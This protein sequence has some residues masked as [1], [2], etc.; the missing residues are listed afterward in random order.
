MI[1]RCLLLLA[2]LAG[3]SAVWSQDDDEGRLNSATFSGLKMRTTGPA[4]MS[5]RVADIA[6]HPHDDNVWY[7]AVGS[8]GVWK[9]ANAGITWSSIFD[10]QESYSIGALSIDQS[11]PSI[12]WVG[13]GE[14]VGGRHVGFGDG[15]YRSAD[16]GS[17]WK[18][19]GLKES[20]HISKIIV[21]P[22]NSDVVWV[23][24]QGPLWSKGGERGLYKTSDAGNTWTR[25]L[26]GDE[27]D[28]LWTGV[29]DLV[30]D[31]RNPDVL[32]AAT[33]QRHRT[34]AAYVGGG[35]NSG[36]HRSYDGGETWEKLSTGL[37]QGNL[38]KIGLA[39][40][41]Q[42]PDVLYAAIE[43]NQRTGGVYRSADRGSSWQKRSDT[44]SGGT[45]PHYYQEL[46]ASPHAFDRLYLM[47]V[48]IQISD[49]G[50][51]TFRIMD[52][53]HKH[54]DNHA[55]VFRADDPD[56]LLAGTDGG[57]YESF[58]LAQNWR[59]IANLPVTQFYKIAVDDKEPFYTI[60]GGTQDNSTQ[61]GPSRTD[62]MHGARNSDWEIVLFADGHQPATE[63][64]NPDIMYAEWQQG[65]LVRVDRT[66]GEIVYIQPQPEAGE[67]EERF[68]WDAPVLVSAHDP[69]RIYF[70]SQRV[71]RSDNR[72]D[73]WRALSED[74]TRNQ[75]RITLEVMGRQW[76]WDAPWDML[77][78]S[79]YN[80]ITSLAESP[81]EDGILYAG[82]DD[83]FI[84]VTSDGGENWRSIAVSKLPGVPAT[85][86][87]NDIKADLFDAD[88]VY[89]ALDNHKYGDFKPYLLR[90]TDR[91]RSWRS[92][93]GDLPDRHLVW[94]LVQDHVRPELMFAGTEFG[95][96][97]T[98][99][100]GS[101]WVKLTGDV[102]TISFRD[103]AIQRREND[104][105]GGSF[106]RGIWIL[107]DYSPLREVTEAMLDEE[108]T[109]FDA[110]KAWWYIERAVLGFG[111]KGSMGEDLYTAD[112]P[113]FGAVFT[114]YLADGYQT[115]KQERT[116]QEKELIEAAE[117]VPF[118]GWQAVEAERR[119][120]QPAIV[121]TVR[122]SDGNVVRR[123][124][125]PA[126]KGF[127]R[128]AWDLR[129]P[130]T[131]A[132]GSGGGGFG[133]PPQGVMV[134]PGEYSVSMAKR[135]NGQV[136]E[137]AGPKPFSVE[138]MRTGALAGSEPEQTAA[139]WR[140]IAELQRTTS[141]ANQVITSS[142]EKLANLKIALDRTE[143]AP[144]DMDNRIYQLE[145]ELFAIEEQL[146][147]NQSKALVGENGPPTVGSRLSVA[148]IGTM[149]STY[150][151][152]PVH[153]RSLEIAEQE[154][155]G[156]QQRLKTLSEQS[157]PALEQELRDAGAPWTPG[158]PLPTD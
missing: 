112:N 103:L 132:V 14:N 77:A 83:G 93:A 125:G 59:Y 1:V 70:A 123:L 75:E 54:S 34:V 116:K 110:R 74:L 156:I 22:D 47:D 138:R 135:I 43:L 12:I 100:A 30:I 16:G 89:V 139:F 157:I 49:D 87:V 72:G 142:R 66:T 33:W 65:N 18:N 62:N 82:T 85:A 36:I 44:V 48:R 122:D 40:S 118:P 119:Q 152:T 57:L 84:Q 24:V 53:A 79:S 144:G 76:S 151:P 111:D 140:E 38:G 98:I 104:L 25:T 55:L 73:S 88:T 60:Y 69:K 90:S 46:V 145:Q 8:G 102:P 154:F 78:M 146:G 127:N 29:T 6:I 67:P 50:G 5:G 155:A 13:T 121:L 81:V 4:F 86:F 58:D 39:I 63:P 19:M 134:A 71:W 42:Q 120:P 51:S 148:M 153:R 147:G 37:P 107:D 113:P 128:L 80:T 158:S 52:E 56:Y 126:G 136:T 20:E 106:G 68:N 61:A 28:D 9:T 23:A 21:H 124:E 17:S 10:G 130:A 97:F 150:G 15:I 27:G 94:R 115:D 45:G 3:N 117:D 92:M 131:T 109:L 143:I 32:Y 133:G 31:P 149:L 101:D 64:G 137:L 105:V 108:A 114:Y 41:P 35:P 26:V 91:G 129:F 141:A 2:L 96:F 95:I 7:V 99:N 11:N